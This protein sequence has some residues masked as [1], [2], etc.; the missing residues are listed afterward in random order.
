MCGE[1]SENKTSNVRQV[2]D[3]SSLGLGHRSSM[4]ELAEKP[5]A[6]EE[7]SGNECDSTE[8]KY[9]QHHLNSILRIRNDK[10]TH[11]SRDRAA[12]TEIGDCGMRVR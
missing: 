6:Y 9:E 12:C 7:Y 8:N 5:E 2:S 10:S 4:N 1:R 3:A 11:N